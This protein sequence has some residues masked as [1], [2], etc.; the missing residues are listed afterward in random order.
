MLSDDAIQQIK[1]DVVQ[2][3]MHSYIFLFL[4]RINICINDI[5]DHLYIVRNKLLLRENIIN[6]IVHNWLKSPRESPQFT[7]PR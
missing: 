6:L 4:S 7:V 3:Q 2:T 1:V 5:V